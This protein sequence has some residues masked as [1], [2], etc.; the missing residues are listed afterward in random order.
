VLT[1]SQVT[2][3]V[4]V[5]G[6]MREQLVQYFL[7]GGPQLK[8]RD[9]IYSRYNCYHLRTE[10]MGAVHLEIGVILHNFDEYGGEC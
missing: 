4:N 9:L 10:T 5:S 2:K 7:G 3:C 8:N 1:F 6:T